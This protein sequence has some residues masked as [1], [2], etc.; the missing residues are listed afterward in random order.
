MRFAI[1]GCGDFDKHF[2]AI[3]DEKIKSVAVCDKDKKKLLNTKQRNPQI[4]KY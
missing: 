4:Y 1:I 3:N 2:Q